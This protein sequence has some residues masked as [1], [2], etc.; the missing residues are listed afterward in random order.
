MIAVKGLNK[1]A[2]YFRLNF[3]YGGVLGA[4]RYKSSKQGFE[5]LKTQILKKYFKN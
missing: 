3:T 4:E 2:L 1:I 5:A